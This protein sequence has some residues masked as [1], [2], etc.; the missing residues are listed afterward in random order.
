M[1]KRSD[2]FSCVDPSEVFDVHLIV[3]IIRR[4]HIFPPY[5]SRFDPFHKIAKSDGR[6]VSAQLKSS[7]FDAK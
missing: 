6:I 1:S 5:F 2:F 3:R 4:N 7:A